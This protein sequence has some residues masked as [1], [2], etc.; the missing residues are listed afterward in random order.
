MDKAVSIT[1]NSDIDAKLFRDALYECMYLYPDTKSLVFRNLGRLSID[2]SRFEH[3]KFECLN[4]SH[5]SA[6]EFNC[7][8]PFWLPATYIIL[9]TDATSV[10]LRYCH[11]N[12]KC[13]AIPSN[14]FIPAQKH[15]T[16][17]PEG[18]PI[19]VD[20]NFFIRVPENVISEY[21]RNPEWTS[22]Q[23]IDENGCIFHPQFY[24]YWEE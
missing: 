20:S 10:P 12:I 5:V 13:I 19:R 18:D 22:I 23:L 1:F 7:S 2:E 24:P 9:P 6:S 21:R 11:P 15:L 3:F 16:Y 8:D 4:F 14:H 17:D